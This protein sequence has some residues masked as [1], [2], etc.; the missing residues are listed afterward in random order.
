MQ[1]GVY[2]THRP[3]FTERMKDFFLERL[4][5]VPLKKL[6]PLME[7]FKHWGYSVNSDIDDEIGRIFYGIA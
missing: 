5:N 4:D 7:N 2:S 6:S 1:K 3:K